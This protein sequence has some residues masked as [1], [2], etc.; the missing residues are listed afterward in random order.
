MCLR[1]VPRHE[2]DAISVLCVYECL[3]SGTR[4][5][6]THV[7]WKVF[8]SVWEPPPLLLPTLHTHTLSCHILLSKYSS[9]WPCLS[10]PPPQSHKIKTQ[11]QTCHVAMGTLQPGKGHGSGEVSKTAWSCR[12]RRR[13]DAE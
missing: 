7:S 3:H 9:L 2:S 5:V 10:P 12:S 6:Q 11:H 1:V 4:R 13:R 8:V